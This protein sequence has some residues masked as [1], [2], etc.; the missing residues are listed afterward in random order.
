M[1]NKGRHT[2]GSQFY[3]TLQPAPWMDKKFT[4][5]GYVSFFFIFLFSFHSSN[6]FNLALFVLLLAKLSRATTLQTSLSRFVHKTN[7]HSRNAKSPIVAFSKSNSDSKKDQFILFFLII[8]I[9]DFNFDN[10][11]I[12]NKQT[13]YLFIEVC[14]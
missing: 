11:L 1:A 8:L 4:A 10:F 5:F 2:N 13:K 6:I 7:D 3:I 12:N 14:I 9:I